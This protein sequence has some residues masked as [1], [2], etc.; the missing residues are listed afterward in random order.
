MAGKKYS[1]AKC[2]NKNTII[3][4][5]CVR[6]EAPSG[7]E[8]K[9]TLFVRYKDLPKQSYA[10]SYGGIIRRYIDAGIPIPLILVVKYNQY[11]ADKED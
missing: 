3:C 9:P 10:E 1:C 6:V 5:C 11:T 7:K 4:D 2:A 8:S